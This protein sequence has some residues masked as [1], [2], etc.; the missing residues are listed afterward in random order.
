MTTTITQEHFDAL[1]EKFPGA[2]LTDL[3]NG[4]F[5]CSV[6]KFRLP[7]GWNKKSASACFIVPNGYP[8]AQPAHFFT[9]ADVMLKGDYAPRN[10]DLRYRQEGAPGGMRFWSWKPSIWSPN[11]DTLITYA[12]FI[13]SRFYEVM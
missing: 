8:C 10:T 6:P 7:K 3:K 2:T 13:K 12:N 11:R 9:D 4:T 1:A 5:L